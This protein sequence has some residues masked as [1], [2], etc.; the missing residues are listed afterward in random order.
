MEVSVWN[1]PTEPCTMADVRAHF[2]HPSTTRQ[3]RRSGGY[4]PH[5]R[6]RGSTRL[7]GPRQSAN[8]ASEFVMKV[9]DSESYRPLRRLAGAVLVQA[10]ADISRAGPG[11]GRADALRWIADPGDEHLSFVSC[12]RLLDRNP[13]EVRRSLRRQG[14]PEWAIRPGSSGSE[15]H[16]ITAPDAPSLFHWQG[17][18]R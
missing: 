15:S 16:L 10:I 9:E 3:G 5:H 13:E 4:Q 7:S 11:S 8:V 12:C 1:F 18:C 6:R 2:R 17:A 14:P